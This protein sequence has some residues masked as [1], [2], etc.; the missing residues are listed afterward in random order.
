MSKA[1][2]NQIYKCRKCNKE[3]CP[4]TTCGEEAA[5]SNMCS[6]INKVNGASENYTA[7]YSATL[8]DIHYCENGDFGVADFIGYEKQEF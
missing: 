3:Y 6:C 7:P 4:V 8:Y 2:Y 5:L 1:L